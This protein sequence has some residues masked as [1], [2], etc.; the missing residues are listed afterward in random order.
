VQ[1]LASSNRRIRAAAALALA[2][3]RDAHAIDVVIELLDDSESSSRAVSVLA[4]LIEADVVSLAAVED[5]ARKRGTHFVRVGSVARRVHRRLEPW[6]QQEELAEQRRKRTQQRE[7]RTAEATA[8]GKVSAS[9]LEIESIPGKATATAAKSRR[10]PRRRKKRDPTPDWEWLLDKPK[11]LAFST[12]KELWEAALKLGTF[13][14]LQLEQR[15]NQG[16]SSPAKRFLKFA[17]EKKLRTNKAKRSSDPEGQLRPYLHVWGKVLR[18]KV[19]RVDELRRP[20]LDA[21]V[22]RADEL[23][24]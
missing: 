24:S 11:G 1:L 16:S 3:K 8:T 22:R 6:D 19:A 7:A 17:E 10:K 2:E 21:L 14:R 15:S 20:L 18:D 5:K 12:A 4:R 13:T 9:P 23:A